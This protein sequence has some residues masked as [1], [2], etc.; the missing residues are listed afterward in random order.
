MQNYN[1][2]IKLTESIN[3][4]FEDSKF[5]IEF[6]KELA[7]KQRE[8]HSKK[9]DT[10]VGLKVKSLNVPIEKQDGKH[11]YTYVEDHITAGKILR[12]LDDYFKEKGFKLGNVKL[13][14]DIKNIIKDAKL[15]EP[16]FNDDKFLSNGIFSASY[17]DIVNKNS[18][19]RLKI[20]IALNSI[21]ID[22]PEFDDFDQSNKFIVYIETN[23][24][25]LK[26]L[27]KDKFEELMNI[28]IK[29]INKIA[30]SNWQVKTNDE[31]DDEK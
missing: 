13:D 1:R 19:A 27:D 21:K 8:L 30:T 3:N 24:S 31:I 14:V 29:S 16:L 10:L 20:N 26:N 12:F 6:D 4:I 28:A 25:R 2:K 23:G 15:Y 5:D 7:K 18:K 17:K 9:F 11:T 22:S